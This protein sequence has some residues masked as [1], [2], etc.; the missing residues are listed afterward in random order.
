MYN[1][2]TGSRADP[3]RGVSSGDKG[4]DK[5]EMATGKGTDRPADRH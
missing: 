4:S 3:G 5:R 1:G 2:Y